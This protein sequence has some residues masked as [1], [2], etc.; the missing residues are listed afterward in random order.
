M[1]FGFSGTQDRVFMLG[2]DVIVIYWDPSTDSVAAE[3]YTL[4]SRQEVCV[5]LLSLLHD[6]HYLNHEDFSP[7]LT[8]LCV[9][10]FWSC[11]ILLAEIMFIILKFFLVYGKQRRV[12]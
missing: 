4:A 12:S 10:R 11:T 8:G 6:C 9:F 5:S 7:F 3:D 1:A 2:S